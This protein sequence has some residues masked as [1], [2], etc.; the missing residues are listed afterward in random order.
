M[1]FFV[2]FWP[3]VT[4]GDLKTKLFLESWLQKSHFADPD[5]ERWG[6]WL[7]AWW[8]YSIWGVETK[9]CWLGT[10]ENACSAKSHEW[11][12]NLMVNTS[13][14]K[15][16]FITRNLKNS[17][18]WENNHWISFINKNVNVFCTYFSI[19]FYP[20]QSP[21]DFSISQKVFDAR[22]LDLLPDNIFIIFLTLLNFSIV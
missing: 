8:I 2:H 13:L 14:K 18:Q 16:L 3:W 1:T 20:L 15:K 12:D 11:P 9:R 19:D 4:F 10:L 7:G 22:F 17:A 21:Y 5:S 6:S